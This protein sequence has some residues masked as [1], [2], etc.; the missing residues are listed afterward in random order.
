MNNFDVRPDV[1]GGFDFVVDGSFVREMVFAGEDPTHQYITLLRRGIFEGAIQEQLSA[2]KGELPGKFFP[3]RVWLYFCPQCYDEGCGGVSVKIRV[4]PE[5]VNWSEF[6][7]DG[8]ADTDQESEW[9]EEEDSIKD[10][11]PF[12]FDRAEYE[13]A[14]NRTA[15]QLRRGGT[16]FWR[17]T[18][19]LDQVS[20]GLEHLVSRRKQRK[21]SLDPKEGLQWTIDGRPLLQILN[22]AGEKSS[23][24]IRTMQSGLRYS[25][26]QEQASNFVEQGRSSIRIL[27]GEEPNDE[28]SDRVT[29]FV[30]ETLDV[31]GGAITAR[32]ERREDTVIWCDFRIQSAGSNG[33]ELDYG[34][35]LVFTFNRQQ[36]DAALRQILE[37]A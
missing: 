12:T 28:V 13:A 22:E 2:L 27:L 10:V 7:Y 25:V 24:Q 32:V 35:G 14:L 30:G 37:R 18:A 33:K 6:R 19:E 20:L 29:L 8:V 11:G 23:R 4:G 9:F 34:P 5:H 17:S 3:E 21:S 26:V 36:H 31:L 16:A 1:S 15:D